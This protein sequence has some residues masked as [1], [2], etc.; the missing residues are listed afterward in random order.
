VPLPDAMPAGCRFSTRCP[1]VQD[2]CRSRRP[3]LTTDAHGHAHA[4]LRAPLEDHI[5]GAA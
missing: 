2:V 5:A 3:A 1:F 4:C